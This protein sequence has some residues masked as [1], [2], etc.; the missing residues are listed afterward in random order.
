MLFEETILPEIERI[1]TE[2]PVKRVKGHPVHYLVCCDDRS[3]QKEICHILLEALYANS[4]IQSKRNRN[5]LRIHI[6]HQYRA[7]SPVA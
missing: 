5:G 6:C 4:R 7:I 2:S 1:Y 3:D